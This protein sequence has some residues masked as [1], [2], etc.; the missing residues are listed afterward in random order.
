MTQTTI[1]IKVTAKMKKEMDEIKINWNDYINQCILEKLE[2]QNKS[3]I[4][5]V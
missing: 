3:S 4:P 1:R 2:Q 5:R